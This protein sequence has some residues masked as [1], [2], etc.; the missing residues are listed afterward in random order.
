MTK[1]ILLPVFVVCIASLLYAA[2]AIILANFSFPKQNNGKL[3]FPATVENGLKLDK[4]VIKT[5]RN[6]T[7]LL[8]ENN[9]WLVK[10]E[11]YYYANIELL[12][13]LF[14]SLNTSRYR[15]RQQFSPQIADEDLLAAPGQGTPEHTGTLIETF[16]GENPQPMESIIIGKETANGLYHFARPLDKEEIWLIDGSYILPDDNYSW[17]MQPILD[18]PAEIIEKVVISE[19]NQITLSASRSRSNY[20]F[21]TPEQKTVP[22]DALLERFNFFITEKVLS[23]QNFDETLFPRH[24][25]IELTTFSG[26]VTVVD[27]YYDSND[28]WVKISLSTTTLPTASV[29]AYI[30]DNNFLYDGWFF[31]IPASNGKVLANFNIR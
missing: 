11:D 23:A 9:F 18:Y 31:K 19:N 26:M 1:R 24:R 25:R 21:F 22:L 16:A 6:Q 14:N 3:V 15:H 12:N 20:P 2:T 8:L 17:L 4:V 28:Y 7:T 13:E 30:R 29:N 27:L 10:E 5:P